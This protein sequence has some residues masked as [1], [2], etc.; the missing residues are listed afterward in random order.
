MFRDRLEFVADQVG[1][2]LDA[3]L[4]DYPDQPVVHAMRY[5]VSGGKRLRAFLVVEGA[6]LY[7]VDPARALN[8][9]AAI[10]AALAWRTDGDELFVVGCL[11]PGEVRGD[12]ADARRAESAR[13]ALALGRSDAVEIRPELDD[14]ATVHT[15]VDDYDPNPFGL[16]NML[17]NVAEWCLDVYEKDFYA[18]SPRE[19]PVN[20]GDGRFRVLRGGAFV[21][22]AED[23][24]RAYRYRLLPE[25]RTPYIGFRTVLPAVKTEE[26]G[27]SR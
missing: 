1:A 5:A 7:G 13:V 2:H 11:G 10:E 8:A 24:R 4:A 3:V 18:R 21:L 23:L 26:A 19:N 6:A 25:D 15:T 17:G 20:R 9:A 12:A 16:H 22:E 14:H 27:G